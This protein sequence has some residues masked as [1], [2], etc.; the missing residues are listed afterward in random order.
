MTQKKAETKIIT[1]LLNQKYVQ[2]LVLLLLG[3]AFY[4]FSGQ[5][6]M[7]IEKDSQ[8]YMY[9]TMDNV[10]IMP[11]YPLFLFIIRSVFGE[12]LYLDAAVI[13]QS[14]LALVLT[15]IFVLYLQRTFQLKFAETVLLYIGTMLPFSIELPIACYTH[16]IMTEAVAYSFFYVYFIFLMQYIFFRKKKW[17]LLTMIM[18]A[19]MG[20]IRSQLIF[21]LIITGIF[22]VFTEFVNDKENKKIK[23]WIK[24]GINLLVSMIAAFVLVLLIYQFREGY[25]VHVLPAINARN[26]EIEAEENE[27]DE[28]GNIATVE[29]VET[30]YSESMS[31]M[32]HLIMIRGFYEADE[33]D[34]A[35]FNTPEMQEIFQRVYD[36]VDQREYRYVYARSGLYMWKDIMQDKIVGAAGKAIRNY[37]SDNPEVQI[38]KEKVVRELGM[39]V[40]LKHFDRYI[41]HSIRLMIPGFI[42][43]VFF[44]IEKIYGLCHVI[45]LLIYGIAIFGMI[46]CKK[47]HGEKKTVGFAFATVG[48]ICLSVGIINIVFTGLQR[49]M[50]YAMGIFYCSM[51]LLMKESLLITAKRFPDNRLLAV[52]ANI[53]SGQ[54]GQGKSLDID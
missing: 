27:S 26:Q 15:M 38:D 12:A 39:K 20:L 13:I 34:I 3:I 49:Y 22:F 18:A 33:E 5:E 1:A 14:I 23:R 8:F 30:E 44:Q 37:M 25:F 10:G 16:E 32:T 36:E 46:Y 54:A 4:L 31:Q 17:L 35:L 41:Y 24:A 50:V 6:W 48:F 42:S 43:S 7:V 52:T 28:K 19:F 21:L 51:Y 45:T 53:L 9:P 11:I 40:L 47:Y 2:I 29:T